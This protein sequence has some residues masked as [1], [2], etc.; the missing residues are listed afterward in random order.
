MISKRDEK[1]KTLF[2][3]PDRVAFP[4]ESPILGPRT[5][6][7]RSR[8]K[9]GA[10][11]SHG[12]VAKRPTPGKGKSI[13]TV[14][15]LTFFFIC[16]I[17]FL[18]KVYSLI[19]EVAPSSPTLTL[20]YWSSFPQAT[21]WSLGI[22]NGAEGEHGLCFSTSFG[23]FMVHPPFL[24]YGSISCKISFGHW[25]HCRETPKVCFLIHT[26]LACCMCDVF[27]TMIV[28]EVILSGLVGRSFPKV[29][30]A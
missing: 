29:K 15:A 2:R 3:P 26:N 13:A 23:A 20:Q 16:F 12:G 19:T 14:R 22:P 8:N 1:H 9:E 4:N 24:R 11:L 7:R 28:G 30:H 21:F 18:Q 10:L 6:K 25:F 27:A 17:L 5:G